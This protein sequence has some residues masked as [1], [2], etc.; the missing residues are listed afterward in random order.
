MDDD[1]DERKGE[2]AGMSPNHVDKH[3]GDR[4]V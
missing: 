2:G 4:Q 3:Q 1:D